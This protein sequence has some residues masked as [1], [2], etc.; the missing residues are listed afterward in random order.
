M[1][2]VAFPRLDDDR[3]SRMRLYVLISQDRCAGR[4]WFDCARLALEGGARREET[5]EGVAYT[6]AE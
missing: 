3:L 4:D 6:S 2:L 5:A 1:K